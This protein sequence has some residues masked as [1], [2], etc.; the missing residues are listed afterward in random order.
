[1]RYFIGF[2]VTIGLIILLIILLFSGGGGNKQ[3]TPQTTTN[4]DSYADTDVVAQ[5]TVDGP[6]NSD[7]KHEQVRI[8]VG[9]DNVIYQKLQG[10]DN[11]VAESHQY[12]NNTNAYSTFLRS[13]QFAGF[14]SG[15]NAP[16]L[17]DYRGYCP[18]GNTYIYDLIEGSRIIQ[19]YWSTSCGKPKTYLGST[20]LTNTLFK[21]Q[22]PDIDMLQNEIGF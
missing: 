19:Q 18:L 20:S 12:P 8:T 1:M 16:A 17:K 11:H 3:Q 13:L 2:L 22:V 7:V 21:Q 4:L 10:Y 6:V 14:K 15:D 9:K 5:V